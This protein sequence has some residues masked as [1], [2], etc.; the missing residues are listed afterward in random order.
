MAFLSQVRFLPFLVISDIVVT[1]KK[2]LLD[3]VELGTFFGDSRD[4]MQYSE[5]ENT[6][7][8][9]H[10]DPNAGILANTA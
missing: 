2:G 7:Q 9:S 4:P 8:M 5:V 1:P 10:R 3:G 6:P